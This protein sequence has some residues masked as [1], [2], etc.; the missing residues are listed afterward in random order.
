MPDQVR[1]DEQILG[2]LLD[3]NAAAKAGMTP[4]DCHHATRNAQLANP[5]NNPKSEI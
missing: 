1:H 2:V 4:A 5:S 3:Y